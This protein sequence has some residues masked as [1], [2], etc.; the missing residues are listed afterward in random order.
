MGW[1]FRTRRI[2]SGSPAHGM[3]CLLPN[4][5]CQVLQQPC[6]TQQQRTIHNHP[7]CVSGC[8]AATG[9]STG[10]C[11]QLPPCRVLL[12]AIQGI[13][14]LDILCMLL[15]RLENTNSDISGLSLGL[16]IPPAGLII[17]GPPSPVPVG[18]FGRVGVAGTGLAGAHIDSKEAWTSFIYMYSLGGTAV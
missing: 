15:L 18:E 16:G 6:C 1:F 7:F 11:I 3:L 4:R 2:V 10:C 14:A 9:S 8:C 17:C 13:Q 5:S 12:T